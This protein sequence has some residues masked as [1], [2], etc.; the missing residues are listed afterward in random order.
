MLVVS[1]FGNGPNAIL[2]LLSR[3]LD[4]ALYGVDG[5]GTDTCVNAP[6]ST[7]AYVLLSSLFNMLTLVVIAR[8]SAAEVAVASTLVL[9][10]TNIALCSTTIMGVHAHALLAKD[11]ASLVLVVAG[12]VIFRGARSG[13]APVVVGKKHT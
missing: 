12:V 1:L 10:L 3:G 9:P 13:Q 8:G 2:E 5:H 7:L 4:C 6:S 11:V